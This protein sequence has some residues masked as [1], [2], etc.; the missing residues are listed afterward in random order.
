MALVSL[1]K[2]SFFFF[3]NPARGLPVR[4]MWKWKTESSEVGEFSFTESPGAHH[5]PSDVPTGRGR[6]WALTSYLIGAFYRIT[7]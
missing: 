6:I 7:Q 4:R 2:G 3:W 1:G 5:S